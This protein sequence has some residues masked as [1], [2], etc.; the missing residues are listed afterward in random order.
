MAAP[1]YWLGAMVFC[2]C[3]S[4][5]SRCAPVHGSQICERAEG[6]AADV[7][8]GEREE[9]ERHA[10]A[11]SL[12]QGLALSCAESGTVVLEYETWH[13]DPA[14]DVYS[15]EASIH[16]LPK[17]THGQGDECAADA[18]EHETPFFFTPEYI[19]QVRRLVHSQEGQVL[20]DD[21][22]LPS[23]GLPV[24]RLEEGL[25]FV[26]LRLKLKQRGSSGLA[27]AV[28]A[29]GEAM[30]RIMPGRGGCLQRSMAT[31]YCSHSA[32]APILE[33]LQLDGRDEA[34]LRGSEGSAPGAN[35]ISPG[36]WQ[37][38]LFQH[39]Q[40]QTLHGYGRSLNTL[41]ERAH[42]AAER[43][44]PNKL[45]FVEIGANDGKFADP[46]YPHV[47]SKGWHGLL[48]EP[49]PDVFEILR[50]HYEGV[51]NL[52][53][54]QA[55]IVDTEDDGKPISITRV[56]LADV[57]A[58]EEECRGRPDADM[59]RYAIGVGTLKPDDKSHWILAEKGVKEEVP[60]MSL[61]TLLEKHGV[62]SIDLFQV[63]SEGYDG[64]I[65]MQLDLDRY[66]PSLVQMEVDHLVAQDLRQVMLRFAQKGYRMRTFGGDLVAYLPR[67]EEEH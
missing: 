17:P 11:V 53:F 42:A 10:P 50:S 32:V 23:W 46:L 66:R 4:G 15:V 41:I 9:E 64:R 59:C 18:H 58:M 6:C 27:K 61:P 26:R 55:A 48:V 25:Y 28:V 49:L 33:A 19:E 63:D 13:V 21:G 37:D 24:S 8:H 47:M 34:V 40:V 57:R 65:V 54:E 38:D 60:G 16:I 35:R 1:S 22:G 51:P 56:P 67:L 29:E 31:D 45:F 44:G 30:V 12:V 36:H 52:R 20:I 14:D 7:G 5:L 43:S 2:C 39:V 3:M 62:T